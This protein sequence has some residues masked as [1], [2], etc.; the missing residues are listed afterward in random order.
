MIDYF[1]NF[2][3]IVLSRDNL[4]VFSL[5]VERVRYWYLAMC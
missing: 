2:V 5:W 3:L 4:L 1:Y